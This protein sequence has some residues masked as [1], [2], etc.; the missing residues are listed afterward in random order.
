M[1]IIIFF[2]FFLGG[3]AGGQSGEQVFLK[4]IFLGG[5]FKDQVLDERFL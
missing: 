4:Q 2:F 5:N 3:G 1:I